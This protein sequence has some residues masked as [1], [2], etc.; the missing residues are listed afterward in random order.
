MHLLAL[1]FTLWVLAALLRDW[2]SRPVVTNLQSAA[3][4]IGE[5][6]YPTVTVCPRGQPVAKI[7]QPKKNIFIYKSITTQVDRWA[8]L[9]QSYNQLLL[10]QKDCSVDRN[11]G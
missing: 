9:E 11:A 8:F 1:A 7:F 6:E 3:V 2:S 4:P 5:L 10:P